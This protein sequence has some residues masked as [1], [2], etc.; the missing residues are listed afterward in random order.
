MKASRKLVA[1]LMSLT[2]DLAHTQACALTRNQTSD[3]SLYRKMLSQLSHAGQGKIKILMGLQ[4]NNC[5]HE[6]M[7]DIQDFLIQ[8]PLLIYV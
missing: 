8:M 1:F 3:L 7:M 2:G 6:W 5:G 4:P